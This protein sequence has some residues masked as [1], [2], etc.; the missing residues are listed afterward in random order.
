MGKDDIILATSSLITLIA[1]AISLVMVNQ[2]AGEI[3]EIGEKSVRDLKEFK[4]LA[5]D[6]WSIM[7]AEVNEKARTKRQQFYT[8]YG[9]FTTVF[10]SRTNSS[11]YQQQQYGQQQQFVQQQS[12]LQQWTQYGRSSGGYIQPPHPPVSP[13]RVIPPAP[14]PPPTV[15]RPGPSYLPSRP[16]PVHVPFPS[17]G[18]NMG[19]I[20]VG[21]IPRG[22]QTCSACA[23]RAQR[24]PSGPPGPPG[25]PGYPGEDG[26]PGRDGA[27]SHSNYGPGIEM[28]RGGCIKCPEGPPGMPGPDGI[29]GPPGMDGM[30]GG[31]SGG[32]GYGRPGPPGPPGDMGMPGSAGMPGSPGAPGAPGGSGGSGRGVPGRPGPPGPMGVP[33]Q[34][35]SPSYGSM[36]G[37]PGPPGRSGSPGM[38]GA[39]GRPGEIGGSGG[40]GGDGQ[41][42]PCPKRNTRDLKGVDG[43]SGPRGRMTIRDGPNVQRVEGSVGSSVRRNP[44]WRT[45]NQSFMERSMTTAQRSITE[46]EMRAWKRE[47]LRRQNILRG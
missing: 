19:N 26:I 27:H 3:S 21:S 10:H 40:P 28:G 42:C 35:G 11:P 23:S 31:G 12:I 4:E 7:V 18:I 38:K 46:S 6:A 33:G 39:P 20:G 34:A 17:T 29:E 25:L 24:C 1:I 37:P 30:P 14:R 47:L 22:G 44:V 45:S 36:P 41:Y 13:P 9:T 43:D 5:D 15:P 8:G 32:G 2:L 16:M